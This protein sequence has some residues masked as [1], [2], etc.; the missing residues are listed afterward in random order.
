[1]RTAVSFKVQ[2]GV[3]EVVDSEV[4]ES[5]AVHSVV[6]GCDFHCWGLSGL[7][8]LGAVDSDLVGC[9]GGGLLGLWTLRW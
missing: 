2:P 6:V 5:K 3:I 7:W 9:P 1:M 4:V 8:T